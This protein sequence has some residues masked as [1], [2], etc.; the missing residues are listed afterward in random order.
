[1][2]RVDGGTGACWL[3]PHE[4]HS[5][6]LVRHRLCHDLRAAGAADA[7]V[8][9]AA[10]VVSELVGNAVRHG[11]AL[12]GGG[13]R[14][15]WAVAAGTVLLEVEDG[16]TGPA[17]AEPRPAG[18]SAEGGRGLAMVGLLAARWGSAPTAS[19]TTVWAEL[20]RAVASA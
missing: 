18:E 19:G 4:P 17:P 6:G 1:M 7:A 9:D 16:G 3:V 8:Q 2:L 5:V 13:L 11:L 14:A 20:P 10:L 12:P 15:R